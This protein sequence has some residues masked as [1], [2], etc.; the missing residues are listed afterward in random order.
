[1]RPGAEI[2]RVLAVVL[3]SFYYVLTITRSCGCAHVSLKIVR[4]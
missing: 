3:F 2:K 1:M 4:D